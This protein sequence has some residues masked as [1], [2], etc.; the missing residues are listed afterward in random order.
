MSKLN[1]II[2]VESGVKTRTNRAVTDAYHALQKPQPMTGISRTYQPR[3]EEG[4][5]L[6][7][8]STR[9]Q[10]R[11]QDIIDQIIPELERLFDVVATKDKANTEASAD[12]VV[13]GRTLVR[14]VP[15]TTLLFLEKQIND[16]LSFV[17]R[18]PILDPAETWHFDEN[19]AAFATAVSQ[20]HRTKKIPRAFVKFP[21][22]DKHPAQV[23]TYTEDVVVGIWSTVKFS[24]ALP[25]TRVRTL[26]ERLVTL[27]DAVK[28]A[29]ELANSIEITDVKLGDP[30]LSYL[31]A[32]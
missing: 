10:I 7:P 21:A 16:L 24:G 15:V 28:A 11:A 2:A 23:D 32:E 27:Q 20:T 3:D 22:T 12:L 8:E 18:L 17:G 25:A 26:T 14:E 29:R 6:P 31:F 19:Q 9:V 30:I 1:Q 13:N 5:Q 4:E